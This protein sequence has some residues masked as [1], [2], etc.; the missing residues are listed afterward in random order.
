[1]LDSQ[2]LALRAGEIRTRLSELAGLS[3]LSELEDEQRSEL[4]RLR[5]EYGDVE[6]RHSAAIIAEDEPIEK[7]MARDTEDAEAREKRELRERVEVGNYISSAQEQRGLD[8]AEAE[9]NAACGVRPGRFPLHILVG[10]ELEKRQTTDTDSET[11]QQTWIDRLFAESMA[12]HVGVTM[13]SVSPG[14]Q[15]VPVTTAGASAGMIER[16]EAKGADAWTISATE[17]KPKRNTSHLVFSL[18]DSYRLPGLE[19]ALRR[20]M[21]MAI[22]E[23]VDRAVFLGGISQGS[24]SVAD[25]VGFNTAPNVAEKTLTQANKVKADKTHEGFVSLI[26]GK[27]ATG[28]DDIRIVASVGANTLWESTVLSVTS[29]TSSVF[30]TLASFLRENGITWRTRGEIDTATTNGKFGA[31]VGLSRGIEGA[32]TAAMWDEGML[33]RDEFSGASKGEVQL[34]LHYFWD[35]QIPRA[36]NFARIKFVS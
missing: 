13:R 1:M 27:H 19:D 33:V 26:D 29:E 2:K 25:I 8:G 17:L 9:Y 4:D 31:F 18:E 7:R 11:N 21:R 6:R 28:L 22:A 34:T 23:S 16:T 10:E 20:D 3:E 12:A 24:A 14:V 5:N 35:F 36:S 32:A 30:K 15:S